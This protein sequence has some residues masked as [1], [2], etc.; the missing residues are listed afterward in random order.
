MALEA[1]HLRFALDVLD[2][3]HVADL[4]RYLSGTI[5]PDSRY[6]SGID[7]LLTHPEDFSDISLPAEDDFRKGWEAHLTYDLLQ[8]A[9]FAEM[10]GS[11]LVRHGEEAWRERTAYKMIQNEIDFGYIDA[12]ELV[13]HLGVILN[14]FGES[15]GLVKKY[16]DSVM[17]VFQNAGKEWISER[18]PIFEMMKSDTERELMNDLLARCDRLRNDPAIMEKI[19]GIYDRTMSI[20]RERYRKCL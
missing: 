14:P 18:L 20:Y 5:Y 16:H 17:N 15:M 4:S 13:F 7:R 3:Y 8:G 6:V 9:V 19:A 2:D 11:T 1:T 12:T 10:S